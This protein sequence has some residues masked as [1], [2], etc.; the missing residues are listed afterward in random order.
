MAEF[1][2]TIDSNDAICPYCGDRRQVDAADY[3]EDT[4]IEGCCNCGCSYWQHESFSVTHH[5][6]PDCA[7]NGDEH[8]YKPVKLPSGTVALFCSVCDA[9]GGE[10]SN[11]QG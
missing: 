9:C 6:R 3:N 1:E 10:V 8:I 4:R 11:D 2:S 5:C 7:I